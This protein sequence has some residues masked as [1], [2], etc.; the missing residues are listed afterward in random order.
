MT[1]WYY[2]MKMKSTRV[3]IFNPMAV[4][5]LNYWKKRNKSFQNQKFTN[6]II[7]HNRD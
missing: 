4:L 7:K 2:S 6:L 1:P 3:P 5:V